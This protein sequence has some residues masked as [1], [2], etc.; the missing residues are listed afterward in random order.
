M[1]LVS[2]SQNQTVHERMLNC[3]RDEGFVFRHPKQSRFFFG[4]LS[5]LEEAQAISEQ[6]TI[7]RLVLVEKRLHRI[8]KSSHRIILM[9]LNQIRTPFCQIITIVQ[10]WNRIQYADFVERKLHE[11]GIGKVVPSEDE[12]ADAYRLFAHGREA[13]QIIER[14]LAKLNGGSPVQMPANLRKRV[15]RYLAEH[16]TARWD[17]AVAASASSPSGARSSHRAHP[18]RGRAR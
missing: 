18:S 10:V 1:A 13:A 9:D 5:Q 16:P 4:R 11:H 15:T 12:L 17:E 6:Q 7:G 3:R 2:E 8:I 14:E